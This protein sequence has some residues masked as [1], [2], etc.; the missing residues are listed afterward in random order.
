MPGEATQRLG[1]RHQLLDEG[2][3][4]ASVFAELIGGEVGTP[5]VAHLM[6]Q[7]ARTARASMRPLTH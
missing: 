4:E 6:G 7:V 5:K 1:A 2:E 3:D